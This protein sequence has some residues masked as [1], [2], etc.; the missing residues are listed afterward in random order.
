MSITGPAQA[1]KRWKKVRQQYARFFA[2]DYSSDIVGAVRVIRLYY[3][4]AT[5]LRREIIRLRAPPGRGSQAR[6]PSAV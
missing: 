4:C 3:V 6:L 2:R 5:T 1:S